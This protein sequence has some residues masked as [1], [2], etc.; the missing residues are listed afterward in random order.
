MFLLVP[1]LA[2]ALYFDLVSFKIPNW[3]LIIS[4]VSAC[5]WTCFEKGE[6]AVFWACFTSAGILFLFYPLYLFGALGAGDVKL[7]AVLSLFL[8]FYNSINALITS[9]F[10]GGLF[11][12]LRLFMS[13][14][15]KRGLP[16]RFLAIHF[17]IP[18]SIGT[19]LTV[20]GGL[21]WIR[22]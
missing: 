18:I 20:Y 3:L 16:D 22:S 10:V 15:Q 17:S 19:I 7:F 4:Y 5:G 12:I 1:I 14:V 6:A 11:A 2:A 13:A 9:L 21:L 8:G